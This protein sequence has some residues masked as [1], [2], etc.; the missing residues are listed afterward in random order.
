MN[1]VYCST[2]FCEMRITREGDYITEI[3]FLPGTGGQAVNED[4][5]LQQAVSQVKAY[6]ESAGRS[7]DLPLR[8]KGTEFQR[9]VWQA[10]QRIPAG[11]V[12]T[13][14]ELARELNTS[15]RAVG[16]ACR[17]NPIPLVIPC[18]RVVSASGLGGFAGE[19]AGEKISLKQKLLAHEGVEI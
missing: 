12:R 17:Q 11:E 10:L 15:A 9:R 2:P 19:T 13:Y 5:L 8:P 14:G 18:H 4:H 3:D 7:F 16:N 1:S 6:V